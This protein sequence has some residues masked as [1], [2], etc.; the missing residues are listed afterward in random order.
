MGVQHLDACMRC[1]LHHLWDCTDV[2]CNIA[3]RRDGGA[4]FIIPSFVCFFAIM[5]WLNTIFGK[6]T[7]YEHGL[8]LRASVLFPEGIWY[9]FEK[10]ARIKVRGRVVCFKYGKWGFLSG[11]GWILVQDP[12]GFIKAIEKYAPD[13]LEVK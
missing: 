5:F 6:L 4:I 9:S 11:P 8:V 2:W 3:V 1:I 7:V 10:I 12:E 13:K